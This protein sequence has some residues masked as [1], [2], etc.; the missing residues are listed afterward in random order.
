M[1]GKAAAK[2][3]KKRT[4]GRGR[5]KKKK[6]KGGFT[7]HLKGAIVKKHGSFA[8]MRQ[9]FG[10]GPRQAVCWEDCLHK[11]FF[12]LEV[13]RHP[14]RTEIRESYDEFVD[15]PDWFAIYFA[16]LHGVRL[17]LINAELDEKARA[18]GKSRDEALVAL[19]EGYY[20]IRVRIVDSMGDHEFHA[21]YLDA[22]R[23]HLLNNWP[24]SKVVEFDDGDAAS[25]QAARDAMK[26]TDY[27]F[28]RDKKVLV[29]SVYRGSRM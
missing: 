12:D 5:G 6:K 16:S 29:E 17:Q 24:T 1:P 18:A 20:I 21:F 10:A 7:L 25:A 2:S 13:A 9:Q 14:S 15:T 4:G 3:R 11:L 22:N 26:H 8:V 27:A 23:R 19:T 28:L